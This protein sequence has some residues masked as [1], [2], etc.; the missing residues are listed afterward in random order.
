MLAEL[1]SKDTSKQAGKQARGK[2]AIH[3][4]RDS[5]G[6][7]SSL[8][9]TSSTYTYVL[10][11]CASASDRARRPCGQASNGRRHGNAAASVDR[12]ARPSLQHV[13]WTGHFRSATLSRPTRVDANEVRDRPRSATPPTR[14]P[15]DSERASARA[16][17]TPAPLRSSTA[18]RSTRAA[19]PRPSSRPSPAARA[20]SASPRS[21]R[22]RSTASSSKRRGVVTLLVLL[23]SSTGRGT[24]S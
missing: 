7:K 18:S 16:P 6:T 20:S 19:W 9:A 23:H 1:A 3:R 12:R 5:R 8:L 15:L 10:H 21:S 14:L 2:R 13:R 4:A 17:P 22:T 11:R 24:G